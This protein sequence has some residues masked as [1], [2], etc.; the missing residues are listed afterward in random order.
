MA[1]ADVTRGERRPQRGQV[2]ERRAPLS[3]MSDSKVSVQPRQ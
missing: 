2:P 3:G 1:K